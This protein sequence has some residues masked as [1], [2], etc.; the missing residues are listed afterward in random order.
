MGVRTA[1]LASFLSI[2]GALSAG[3]EIATTW[4]EHPN[5]KVRLIAGEGRLLGVELVLAPGWKTYWRMPGDAGVP[6]SFDWAGSVNLKS[7]EVLY[8]APV[9]MA[10][11][12]GIAVGYKGTVIFPVQ[13]TLD[14]EAKPAV[15][16]LE[17]AFGVCKDICIPVES[18]LKLP[19]AA[20][21]AWPGAAPL[22]SAL[23]QVPRTT[24]EPAKGTPALVAFS[25]MLTGSA[26]RLT[27][28]TRGATDLYVEAPDGLF[29]PLATK[30]KDQA[31]LTTFVV[32]LEK[33][34]DLAD[35]PGKVLRVTITGR[36][37]AIDTSIPL[38]P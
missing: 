1:C 18:K 36:A 14:D 20:A 8:P 13:V 2:S 15:A 35:L 34:P 24:S 23:A 22:K 5:A 3:A 17:F 30:S 27:F 16:E 28:E 6:P 10:D 29:I 19:I 26:P 32:D 37:G 7:I 4:N 38:K 9:S 11:Q 33:T 21:K 31:D 25:S 12:G